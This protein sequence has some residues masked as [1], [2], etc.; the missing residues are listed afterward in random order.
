MQLQKQFEKNIVELFGN[1]VVH[2][3]DRST[4]YL[5]HGKAQGSW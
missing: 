1:G 2:N 3:E 5:L 4:K